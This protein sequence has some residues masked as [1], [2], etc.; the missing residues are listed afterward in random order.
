[1]RIKMKDRER[2]SHVA[3]ENKVLS[4]LFRKH[5]YQYHLR[6][7]NNRDRI[8]PMQVPIL[9]LPTPHNAVKCLSPLLYQRCYTE[10]GFAAC[11][12]YHT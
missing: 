6:R 8:K 12:W 7:R 2:K 9:L 3:M 1:M 5:S 10:R 4:L 11:P